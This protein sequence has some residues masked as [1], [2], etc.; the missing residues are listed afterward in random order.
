MQMRSGQLI[1]RAL[2]RGE[3]FGDETE[4][5]LNFLVQY[6]ADGLKLPQFLY[7]SHEIDVDLIR[8]YFTEQL[9]GRLEVSL[10]SDGKHFR[11]LRMARENATR[12]VEKRLKSRDNTRAIEELAEILGLSAPPSLIEGF[13][14]AHLAGKYTIASL[15]SFRDGNPDKPNYRRYNIKSLEGKIDDYESIR[16][17]VARRYSKILNENLERPGLLIIDGGKGQVNAARQILADLGMFEIPI[18]GLAEQFETIVFD[19]ERE[20]LQ[21][22][23]ESEALRLVIAVRDECHRFATSANQAARSKE[24]S[25]RLLESVEGIGKKRSEQ[26]MKQFGSLEVL[27]SK[28]AEDLA[29]ESSLPLSVA[30]R[31]LKQLSL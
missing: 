1:G 5:L 7:V 19:D 30:Q 31:L 21:L 9:G 14:I 17:A 29:K 26:L 28:S 16:E 2:Y 22:P 18:I 12:D 10:P 6:Y 13:D 11:I 27:L 3:T 25:F 8:R 23:E 24:A 4:T 15:I 20:D